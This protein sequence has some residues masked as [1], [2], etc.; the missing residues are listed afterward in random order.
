[1]TTLTNITITN[2]DN[3]SSDCQVEGLIAKSKYDVYKS[4]VDGKAFAMKVFPSMNRHYL[5][6][7]S[8][9]GLSHENILVASKVGTCTNE[10]NEPLFLILTEFCKN[11]TF[12]DVLRN[13]NVFFNEKMTRTY[14]RQLVEA[15]EY[16]HENGVYHLDIKLDNIFLDEKFRLRLADFD[17]A[18]TQEKPTFFK[19]TNFYRAPE[20]MNGTFDPKAADIFQMGIVLFALFNGGRMFPYTLKFST[21][22]DILDK[23]PNSYWGRYRLFLE[24]SFDIWSQD[25]KN[26]F[27]DMTCENPVERLNMEEVKQSRWYQGE[28]YSQSEIE[29]IMGE[30][31]Q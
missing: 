27:K 6:E 19:G 24:W 1:M 5:T 18:H 14:F 4:K 28:V 29:V 16:L 20:Q 23:S 12:F 30:D 26:L 9:S 25:F 8:F 31:L 7:S 3:T 15:V 10:K 2:P 13:K 21:W 17:L 22:R 11:G